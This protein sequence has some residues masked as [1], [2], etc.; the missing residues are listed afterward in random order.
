MDLYSGDKPNPG[1][2]EFMEAHLKDRPFRQDDDCY[3]VEDFCRPI[4]TTRNSAVYSMHA[5]HLGKKPHD[6]VESYI[7]HFTCPGDLVLDPFCGSGSTALAALCSGRKAVAIDASPAATFI[8]RFYVSRCDPEELKA[9]FERMCQAVSPDMETL[10]RTTCHRCGGPATIH[11]LIYSNMY[12]CPSCGREV[13][14]FEASAFKP[15]V[16]PACLAAKGVR[17]PISPHLTIAGNKPVAVNFSCRGTCRPRRTTRSIVGSDEERRAF[18]LIDLPRIAELESQRIPYPYPDQFMMHV[19]ESAAP[20]GDEWRPSRNFRKVAHLFTYRN[21]WALAALFSAAG[22]DDDLRAVLTS[23]MLAVSRKAQ[24][25]SGGG[26]YIPGNWA[27]P[28]MSKQRNVLESLKSVFRRTVKAKKEINGRLGTQAACI[29]TQSAESLA[30]IPSESVDY[31]FTD[32]PYGGAVQYAEL[33][34]IWESWLGLSTDW[35]RHEIIVNRSRKRTRRDWAEMMGRAIAECFRVLKPGRWLSMCY[36]DN[37][38][39]TWSD[40]QDVMA[41]AGF[42]PGDSDLATTIDTGLSTYNRRVTDKATKRDLVISFRKPRSTASPRRRPAA[43]TDGKSFDEIAEAAVREYLAAH[44]G[45]TKDRIYD[46]LVSVLIRSGRMQVHD[47][48]ALL[49]RVARCEG[50]RKTRWYLRA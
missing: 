24:H 15:P 9:R 35:H 4:E 23:G 10:Y 21:L 47:F 6:A 48:D 27:L 3:H 31:I 36:H 1:L 44:P 2:R 20:W 40:L 22:D 42:V 50:T 25:L 28:A 7:R 18:R 11:Y 41:R 43:R 49:A 34:F 39:G 12:A 17:S 33:N 29:S 26:G 13:S 19:A 5:Y 38:S 45:C 37:S 16:C 30:A 46:H 8:T 32:P 14:L